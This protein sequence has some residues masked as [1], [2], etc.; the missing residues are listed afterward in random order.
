MT[1]M[2]A[3]T[4]KA[5][6][7]KLREAAD[8]IEARDKMASELGIDWYPQF[9]TVEFLRTLSRKRKVSA[10]DQELWY[11]FEGANFCTHQ[12][13]LVDGEWAVKCEVTDDCADTG[14][15]DLRDLAHDLLD[16]LTYD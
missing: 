4:T 15:S 6:R 10:Y 2:T 16:E 8:V 5:T 9:A 12:L 14:G 13:I 7:A 1:T 3:K 11:D